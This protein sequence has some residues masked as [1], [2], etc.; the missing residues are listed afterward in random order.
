MAPL[1]IGMPV[2]NGESFIGEALESIQN[3]S[4]SDFEIIVC[5]NAST[6]RTQEIA[7]D[8]ACGDNRIRYVRNEHNIG[9]APNFNKAFQ[10]S[11]SSYFK[12]AAHDD[13]L[14]REMLQSCVSILD[15]N[16]DAVL[17]HTGVQV[18]GPS[19]EPLEVYDAE[20]PTDNADP[21]IRYA[22][23][24]RGHK[25]FEV[26]GVIRRDA[27]K[28][29][30]LIGSYAHS[31]GVLL[32]QLALKGRFLRDERPLFLPRR[33]A[34]QSMAMLGDYRQYTEWFDPSRKAAWVF[35]YWRIYF[36]LLKAIQ[37][38]SLT[39]SQKLA[40]SRAW[41]SSLFDKRKLL[42]GDVTY[43]VR[44]LSGAIGIRLPSRK[45]PPEIASSHVRQTISEFLE[46]HVE[47]QVHEMDQST[48]LVSFL[49]PEVGARYQN[50]FESLSLQTGWLVRLNRE[51]DFNR[52]LELVAQ[53]T[54]LGPGQFNVDLEKKTILLDDLSV[55]DEI[56]E[57]L[58]QATG[59]ACST[60]APAG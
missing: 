57:F 6:D 29:S 13:V 53:Q 44:R 27:L 24:L 20:L 16:P 54:G 15:D 35:P 22:C 55:R 23:L 42:K 8:I 9:A 59:F 1:S 17:A 47:F 11:D 19:L 3:Q 30:S 4:F 49:T 12:W 32:A 60:R 41:R 33:H 39:A 28:N 2:F 43:Q 10:L 56:K 21:V 40:C 31:D 45:M 51:P 52:I 46:P 34:E 7:Q 50:V 58:K 25:C 5:D 18:V 38:S 48:L 37:F 14:D 26:F 36:E